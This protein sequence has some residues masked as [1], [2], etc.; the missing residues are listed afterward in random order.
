MIRVE[1]VSKRFGGIAALGDVTLEVPEGAC[2]ALMGENGAGKST[3]GKVVAGIHR[4]DA[5][6][7]LV[8][9]VERRFRDPADAR[10]AGVAMVHQEL[11]TC[12]DLSV[13]ENLLLGRLPT[14][15][16]FLD[17]R[18]ME[19][20]ARELLAAVGVDLDVRQPMRALST[21]QEQLV[22]IAAAVG[23]GA[24]VLLL[25]EP[26]SSLSDAESERLFAL[27]ERLR[28]DGVTML[29]VSHR[30]PE[31]LRL[32]DRV[33]V[34]RDGELVGSLDRAEADEASLVRLMIGRE[35]V[36]TTPR[37]L[38]SPPGDVLL[39]VRGLSSPEGF[40]DVDLEVRA[41][42]VL[43]LAGLVGAG[44]SALLRALMG[45]DREARG[46]LRVG[47]TRVPVGRPRASLAA[48]LGL[49]PEDRKREGLVLDLGVG[50]NQTLGDLA[51]HRRGPFVDRAAERA[52]AAAA[53]ARVEVKAASLDTPVGT[54]SGGNQ[55]KVVLS[56][57]LERSCRVLLVDEPTRGV[58]VGAKEAI[59]AL[60]DGLA[61]GGAAVLL[62][63]SELP[64]VLGLSTRVAVMREGRIV[65][66]LPRAEATAER[67]LQAMAGVGV[68]V[69]ASAD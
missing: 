39:E 6:R 40:R 9:G 23:T 65:A 35:L 36:P 64:E 54:L 7:V 50:A 16:P 2:H 4:P 20:S 29:Y 26:T 33:H 45:H 34:L 22:Q 56:R 46:A 38:T 30:I 63:S 66:T 10:A 17:R 1:G 37:H 60:L 59:H 12:P 32:C 69:E 48:G 47:G 43:G 28:A 24:R 62:V 61:C 5:G 3:L 8:G 11:A 51:R 67:V 44:R 21:A 31:V 41:G 27:M 15:G 49:V 53:L 14:R 25:D 52:H 42:E 57:W 68:A 13:A 55:Q 58:D 18:A 19:A